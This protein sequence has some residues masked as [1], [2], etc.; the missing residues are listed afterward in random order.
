MQ[1]LSVP[2]SLTCALITS[3]TI[4]TSYQWLLYIGSLIAAI[5]NNA[6]KDRPSHSSWRIPI[7][8]QFVWALIL[9][10]GMILVPESPR[11]LI[12]KE[13]NEDAARA[14]SRL[15]SLPPDHPEVLSQLEEIRL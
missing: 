6:T 12:T 2:L 7:S 11:W 3:G 15:T 1:S 4:V 5:V 9:G 8:I 14:L 13:R 10:V